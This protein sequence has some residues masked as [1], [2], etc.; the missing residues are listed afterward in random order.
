MEQVQSADPCT[1]SHSDCRR[2]YECSACVPFPS[3]FE[4]RAHL[5]TMTPGHHPGMLFFHALPLALTTTPTSATRSRGL[6]ADADE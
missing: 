6:D 5:D 3:R 1:A 2:V 4:A